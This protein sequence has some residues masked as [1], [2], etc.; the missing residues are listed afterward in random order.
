MNLRNAEA[1]YEETGDLVDLVWIRDAATAEVVKNSA[2]VMTLDSEGAAKQFIL[3]Q[4]DHVPVWVSFRIDKD[5]D[6]PHAE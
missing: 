1:N 6:E 4:S 3:E 5:L 2:C